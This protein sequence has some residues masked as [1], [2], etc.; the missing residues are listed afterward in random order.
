[1]KSSNV[2]IW[3]EGFAGFDAVKRLSKKGD[4]FVIL[5]VAATVGFDRIRKTEWFEVYVFGAPPMRQAE[6]VRRGDFIRVEGEASAHGKIN[7]AGATIPTIRII[8]EKV[9]I[10][11][12]Q[13]GKANPPD[14]GAVLPPPGAENIVAPDDPEGVRF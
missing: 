4:E 8:A 9:L 7:K 6:A 12:L 14:T 2:W 3:V 11:K 1:M 5:N 13:R 10:I